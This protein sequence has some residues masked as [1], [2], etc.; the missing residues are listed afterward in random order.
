[1]YLVHHN[2]NYRAIRIQCHLEDHLVVHLD[3]V[4]PLYQVSVQL[5]QVYLGI[6]VRCD[7]GIKGG[8]TED[9]DNDDD[10]DSS[11]SVSEVQPY[12]HYIRIHGVR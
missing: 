8:I 3:Q 7:Y 10:D 1:M 9:D 12:V 4:L 11:M 2:E 5:D 6:C